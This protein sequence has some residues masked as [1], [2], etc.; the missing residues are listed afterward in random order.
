MSWR[1]RAV[2]IAIIVLGLAGAILV[3]PLV[4]WLGGIARP[5]VHPLAMVA[6]LVIIVATIA[7]LERR[8]PDGRARPG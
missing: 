7:T 5:P 2:A 4:H 8:L 6:A 3:V 1:Q